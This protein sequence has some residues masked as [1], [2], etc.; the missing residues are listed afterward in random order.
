MLKLYLIFQGNLDCNDVVLLYFISIKLSQSCS[1][2]D[3][4]LIKNSKLLKVLARVCLFYTCE[5][6]IKQVV[7]VVHHL[8][9]QYGKSLNSRVFGQALWNFI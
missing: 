3:E 4:V 5:C 8:K 6:K 7:K 9:F 1:F 2:D